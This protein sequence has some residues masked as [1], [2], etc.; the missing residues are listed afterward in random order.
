MGDRKDYD[1]P[2]IVVSSVGRMLLFELAAQVAL[3]VQPPGNVGGS[4][5][6]APCTHTCTQS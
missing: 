6:C 5:R 4:L 3:A 2:R 1:G